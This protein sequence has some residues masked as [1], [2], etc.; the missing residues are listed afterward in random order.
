MRGLL[1]EGS[2]QDGRGQD[3]N[4]GGTEHWEMRPREDTQAPGLL[5]PPAGGS[6]SLR[7]PVQGVRPGHERRTPK[8]RT[9]KVT[10]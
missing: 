4:Q 10:G 6:G 9:P 8:V 1:A 3:L 5:S 7:L 2:R